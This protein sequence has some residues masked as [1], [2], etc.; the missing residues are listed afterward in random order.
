M[1]DKIKQMLEANSPEAYQK[2]LERM[3]TEYISSKDFADLDPLDRA[4][5]FSDYMDIYNLVG[6][7]KAE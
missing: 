4:N 3:F 1:R 7:L 5:T 2:T 6:M